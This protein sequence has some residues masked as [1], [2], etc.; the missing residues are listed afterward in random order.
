M[1]CTRGRRHPFLC[2]HRG[3]GQICHRCK[4]ADQMLEQ[5][6]KLKDSKPE[7]GKCVQLRE[8]AARLKVIPRKSGATAM[9][10]APVAI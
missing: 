7:Q 10:S 6:E 4:Q 3:Y 1:A 8:E 5:A 2:G 9:P